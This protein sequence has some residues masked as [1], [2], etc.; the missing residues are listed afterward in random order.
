MSG[1]DPVLLDLVHRALQIVLEEPSAWEKDLEK[2]LDGLLM[3]EGTEATLA[4]LGS[5]SFGDRV[6]AIPLGIWIAIALVAGAL[7]G[8]LCFPRGG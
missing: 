1:P 2:E 5:T 7:L 4:R 6:R 3:E 8:A